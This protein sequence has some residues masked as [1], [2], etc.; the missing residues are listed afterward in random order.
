MNLGYVDRYAVLGDTG[1][2]S[3]PLEGYISKEYA[4]QRAKLIDPKRARPVKDLSPGD[5]L[6]F[7]SPSITHLSVV[8][9]DG[10]V[11]SLIYSVGSVFGSGVMAS[12]TGVLIY[13][14][15]SNFRHE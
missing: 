14:Q 10:N 1:Y 9:L 13:N 12:G 7:E 4:A 15:V 5:T 3:I 8:D 6:A 11:V 2:V